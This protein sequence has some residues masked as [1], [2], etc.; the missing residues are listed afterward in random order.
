MK[1]RLLLPADQEFADAALYYSEES[2]SAARKF[3]EAVEDAL[4][5]IAQN[6]TRY[7]R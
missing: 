3:K 4:R 7:R 5:Q 2:P 6:P 1:L